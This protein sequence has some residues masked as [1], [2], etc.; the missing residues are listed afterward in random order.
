MPATRGVHAGRTRD[1]DHRDHIERRKQKS[2]DQRRGE[3]LG[4]RLFRDQR[5]DREDHRGRDQDAERAGGGHRAGGDRVVVAMA[6]HLGDR[7]TRERRRSGDRRAADGAERR[8]GANR[9]VGKRAAEPREHG[10]GRF[11]ELA[12][13][14]GARGDRAHQDEERHHRERIGARELEGHRAEH[15]ERLRQ[16]SIAA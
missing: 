16:P 11:E 9:G 1:D 3:Q 8:A 4:E 2:G 5:V 10:V 15:G 12:R 6:A 14:A 7:D 13:H